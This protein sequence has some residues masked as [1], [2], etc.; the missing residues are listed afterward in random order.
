MLYRGEEVVPLSPKIAETLLVLLENPNE[1]LDRDQ[2]MGRIWPDQEE[3]GEGSLNYN[4]SVLRKALGDE[5][6]QPR[7]ILTVPGRG[8]K[9]IASVDVEPA[10]EAP[11]REEVASEAI[12]SNSEETAPAVS[13]TEQMAP[14][15]APAIAPATSPAIAPATS[16]AIIA[17]A[18]VRG[19][20]RLHWAAFVLIGG[21]IALP[22]IWW[23]LFGPGRDVQRKRFDTPPKKIT[24][25]GRVWDAAFSPEG[26]LVAY[27]LGF[28]DR[29]SLRVRQADGEQDYEVIPSSEMR[30]RGV[31]FSPDGESIYYAARVADAHTLY[32]LPAAGGTARALMSGVDSLVTF[33]P[34][35]RQLA[36]I[37]EDKS[38][39]TSSL[40]VASIDGREARTL[41]QRKS[42]A[43][44]SVEG[45]SWSPDGRHIVC[46]AVDGPKVE[47]RAI[48]I[49][50]VTGAER[51]I[52]TR[53]WDWMKRVAWLPDG[54]GLLVLA[55]KKG[56]DKNCQLWLLSYPD[57]E[58]QRITRDLNDYRG[59]SLSAD[60]RRLALVATEVQS[61]IWIVPADDA[62]RAAPIATG[63][64]HGRNG[65]DWTPDGQIVFTSEVGGVTDLQIVNS[66]GGQPRRL[67]VSD[68]NPHYPSVSSD[69]RYA[70]F[71]SGRNG[72]PRIWRLG[73]A[74]GELLELT[75]GDLD[76]HPDFSPDGR[77][78]IY[79]SVRSGVRRLW[80]VAITGG[81]AMALTD[82]HAEY[83]AVSPDGR[84]VAFLYASGSTRTGQVAIVPI[85]GG[86]AA[87]LT[88]FP[89]SHLWLQV[90]WTPDG[91]SLSYVVTQQ[92]VSNLYLQPLAGGAAKKLTD[93]KDQRIFAYAWSKDGRKIAIARGAMRG[94][95]VVFDDAE[96]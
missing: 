85:E 79:S 9:F 15:V 69:G 89:G 1:V 65:L 42:P 36:F 46:A 30:F 70:V 92:G 7:F 16:P 53:A 37:S 54:S 58:A 63:G 94:D 44:F 62:S 68:G 21:F 80:R 45:P 31:T 10:D 26:D 17:P 73:L 29:Q 23:L 20:S 91:K 82:A 61:D 33:S 48:A 76:I 74:T 67:H 96:R 52:G 50:V 88:S 8:Y 14:A 22:L 39:G 40:V 86:E 64:I 35:G 66:S 38:K 13:V 6:S 3:I 49:D 75:S 56:R 11:P 34:D 59:L 19:Y 32:T 47:F 81:E 90:D 25:A 41:A 18:T 95:V 72:K 4:I 24:S 83:P 71:T 28:A 5:K 77:W 51:P 2:L 87:M 12:G 57:G 78:V 27:V 43:F 60:G 84:Q 93:F 55:R